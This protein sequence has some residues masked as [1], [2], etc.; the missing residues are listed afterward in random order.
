MSPTKYIENQMTVGTKKARGMGKSS[1]SYWR[2][3]ATATIQ[4]LAI[5]SGNDQRGPD[6]AAQPVKAQRSG[7]AKKMFGPKRTGSGEHSSHEAARNPCPPA[8]MPMEKIPSPILAANVKSAVFIRNKFSR[9][10]VRVC[11]SASF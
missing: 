9:G 4:W 6:A 11:R 1:E 10:P 2:S 8:P 7:T 3:C 5:E